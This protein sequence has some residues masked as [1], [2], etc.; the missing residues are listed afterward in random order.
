M[1]QNIK[2]T[3]TPEEIDTYHSA[4]VT[5]CSVFPFSEEKF[6]AL[7]ELTL[8]TVEKEFG[9]EYS[10]AIFHLF[11]KQ[12]DFLYYATE[13]SLLDLV[14]SLIG[15]DICLMGSALFIKKS[16]SPKY[17][18]WHSDVGEQFEAFEGMHVLSFTIAITPSTIES[19]CVKYLPYSHKKLL[20][21]YTEKNYE[22]SLFG[23]RSFLLE[24]HE[25]DLSKGV[26]QMELSPGQCSFNNLNTIHSSEPNKSAQDRIL[27]NFK[28]LAPIPGNGTP[29]SQWF[30]KRNFKNR[31]LVRGSDKG[32]FCNL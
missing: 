3:L 28:Y 7:S 27:V 15:P 17:A 16:G 19:G 18:S 9:N 24:D 30:F 11:A 13:N 20:R 29:T 23:S 6:K 21:H 25:V 26:V 22:N 10:G 1:E 2:R 5:R 4:G 14:E 12:P 8:K 32:N 31:I